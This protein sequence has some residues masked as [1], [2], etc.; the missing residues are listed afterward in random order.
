MEVYLNTLLADESGT[1]QHR[2]QLDED[3]QI[4]RTDGRPMT[5]YHNHYTLNIVTDP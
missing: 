4:E 2:M 1:L 3:A 5:S